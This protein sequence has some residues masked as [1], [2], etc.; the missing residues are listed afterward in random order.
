RSGKLGL[1]CGQTILVPAQLRIAQAE[2]VLEPGQVWLQACGRLQL[3]NRALEFTAGQEQ[4]TSKQLGSSRAVWDM[5]QTL[6]Q[7]RH[8]RLLQPQ[9]RQ[10]PYIARCSIVRA[11]C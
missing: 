7:C 1:K 10:A 8:A 4:L 3:Y 9:A 6:D 11:R 2:G 5:R